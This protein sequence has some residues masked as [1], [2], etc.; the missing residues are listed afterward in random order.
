MV[1]EPCRLSKIPSHAPL[2]RCEEGC[3]KCDI[4]PSEDEGMRERQLR[5]VFDDVMP[6]DDTLTCAAE[7]AVEGYRE[8]LGGLASEDVAFVGIRYGDGVEAD[9]VRFMSFKGTVREWWY[10]TDGTFALPVVDK[11]GGSVAAEPRYLELSPDGK[12][13]PLDEFPVNRLREFI[14]NEQKVR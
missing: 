1:V 7:R 14:A 5:R 3:N 9:A 4:E 6:L 10:L 13:G 12:E 2:V 8:E 11:S